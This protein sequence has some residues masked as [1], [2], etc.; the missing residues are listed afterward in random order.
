MTSVLVTGG[1]GF[2][3]RELVRRLARMDYTV[4]ALTRRADRAD[5]LGAL[6]ATCIVG[7]LLHPGVWGARAAAVDFVVHLAQPRTFGGRVTRARAE[8]YQRERLTMDAN[9]LAAARSA[10]RIV[11]VAGTSYYGDT[12]LA[13]ATEDAPPC[14]RG[15][16]PYIAPAVERAAREAERGLPIVLAFPGY[17]YGDGSWFREY[18]LRPLRSGA[19]LHVVAGRSRTASPVHL[20]DCARALAHLL[21]RGEVG[22][23]YFV[24]DDEPQ[25]WSTFYGR[26]AEAA[27]VPLRVRALSPRTLRWLVGPVVTDSLTCDAAL[28]NARL[29]RSGFDF[30]LPTTTTGIPD[31][32]RNARPT[33]ALPSTSKILWGQVLG[34]LRG[35]RKKRSA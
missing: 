27:G 28:S 13:L 3:G 15:W 22:A 2:I 10:R 9:L 31:V 18:V 8:A 35:L 34:Q 1:T 7:D 32:V 25:P 4:L 26:A 12:G 23:R 14:P 5:A 17:V 19:R 16:G 30:E 20:G 33:T 21:V 24:V 6:G 11:Y 29:R